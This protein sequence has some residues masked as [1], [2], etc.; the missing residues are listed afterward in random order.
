M[1]TNFIRTVLVVIAIILTGCTINIQYPEPAPNEV[2]VNVPEQQP[3]VITVEAPMFEKQ[4]ECTMP[5][6]D[7]L[8]ELKKPELHEFMTK[9]DKKGYL[10]ALTGFADTVNELIGELKTQKFI[11]ENTQ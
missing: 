6:V 11:C 5:A 10:T 4:K 1:F 7:K 9:D 2:T 8:V 3:P